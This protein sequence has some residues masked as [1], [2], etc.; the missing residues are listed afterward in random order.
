MNRLALCAGESRRNV[1]SEARDPRRGLRDSMDHVTGGFFRPK[2]MSPSLTVSNP[3]TWLV[4]PVQYGSMA[5]VWQYGS[6][7]SS[8]VE[9][10]WEAKTGECY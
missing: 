10:G 3:C 5:T 1:L 2:S 8:N 7:A 4:L 9:V 6:P